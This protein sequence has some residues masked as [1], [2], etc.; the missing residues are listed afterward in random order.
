[1]GLPCSAR[2]DSVCVHCVGTSAHPPS[3]PPAP[4]SA[5]R[6]LSSVVRLAL[7]GH[8]G[9]ALPRLHRAVGNAPQPTRTLP[10]P[11]GCPHPHGGSRAT[12]RRRCV[13]Q[14]AHGPAHAS[15]HECAAAKPVCI[16]Q[17]VRPPRI[18]RRARSRCAQAMRELQG[19]VA[20]LA[21]RQVAAPVGGAIA[22]VAG[23]CHRGE[24]LD[25]GW[26][27]PSPESPDVRVLCTFA[28]VGRIDRWGGRA[29]VCLFACL[30]ESVLSGR[31]FSVG[32]CAICPCRGGWALLSLQ[33]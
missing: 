2:P 16:A 4:C 22:G 31:P 14:G 28:Y 29:L 8:C 33:G 9:H 10:P 21:R 26:A 23:A 25:C 24:P 19:H 6:S 3:C 12:N 15:K 11:P 32:D 20:G 7:P 1:M 5:I 17:R 13:R 18:Q 30:R 27:G